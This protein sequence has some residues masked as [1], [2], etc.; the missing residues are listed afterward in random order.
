MNILELELYAQDKGFDSVRFKFI[1]KS[2]REQIGVWLDAYM[3][4]FR[5]V[6]ASD[7]GFLTTKQWLYF[8]KVD[9]FDFEPL[10][11][12]KESTQ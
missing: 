4:M 3:G 7:R 12:E 5:I 6:T 1:D 9:E 10:P 11:N 2:G 8:F